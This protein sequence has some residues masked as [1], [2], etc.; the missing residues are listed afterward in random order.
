MIRPLAVTTLASIVLTVPSSGAAQ[1]CVVHFMTKC[2]MRHDSTPSSSPPDRTSSTAHWTPDAPR[3]SQLTFVVMHQQLC[4]CACWA[5]IG[6]AA[7]LMFRLMFCPPTNRTLLHGAHALRHDGTARHTRCL[8]SSISAL[9]A[10]DI[11]IGLSPRTTVLVADLRRR[12]DSLR[13][14]LRKRGPT[15]RHASLPT[16]DLRSAYRCLPQMM[17]S[18]LT[19]VHCRPIEP[20]VLA[21]IFTFHMMFHK[22]H[23]CIAGSLRQ[24]RVN[25]R[26]QWG[27]GRVYVPLTVVA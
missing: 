5:V 3:T 21:F 27:G 6:I 24:H 14:L 15:Y 12:C 23:M 7:Q 20:F 19:F 11:S 16:I 17:C 4:V 8:A 13:D 9:F 25:T 22:F 10:C 2:A 1:A 26:A 18:Y